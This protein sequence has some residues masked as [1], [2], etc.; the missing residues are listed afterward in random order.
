MTF[1]VVWKLLDKNFT[2]AFK[3]RMNSL[4]HLVNRF[5]D[6]SKKNHPHINNISLQ[7]A[8]ELPY[9]RAKLFLEKIIFVKELMT[10]TIILD[11]PTPR[12]HFQ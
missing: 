6:L 11:Y 10:F 2:K 8:K 4:E 12:T 1:T 3:F 9:T 5:D 7:L